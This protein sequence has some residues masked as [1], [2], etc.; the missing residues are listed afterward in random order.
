MML[1][2]KIHLLKTKF[3]E[4]NKHMRENI[5]LIEENKRKNSELEKRISLIEEALKTQNQ[6]NESIISQL[7]S[8]E[9]ERNKIVKDIQI[10]V[11]TLKDVYSLVQSSFFDQDIFSEELLK[12]KKK[13]NTYH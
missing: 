8:Q 4:L 7:S 5:T 3:L 2:N 10:I 12:K 13:N 1:F 9:R 11:A 6:L